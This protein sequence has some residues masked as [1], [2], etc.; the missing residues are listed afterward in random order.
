M[1]QRSIVNFTPQI[2]SEIR[3]DQTQTDPFKG[4]NQFCL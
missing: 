1:Q 4:E 2:R 3:D